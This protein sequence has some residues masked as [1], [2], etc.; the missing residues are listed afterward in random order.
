LPNRLEDPLVKQEHFELAAIC[1]EVAF[2]MEDRLNR[3]LDATPNWSSLAEPSRTLPASFEVV[4]E[5]VLAGSCG[6][7]P[8]LVSAFSWI[9]DAPSCF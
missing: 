2:Q 5:E 3:A 8:R 4:E 1:E 7:L 6:H 9:E